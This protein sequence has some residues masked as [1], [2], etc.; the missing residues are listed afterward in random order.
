MKNL[1]LLLAAM[2]T[3]CAEAPLGSGRYPQAVSSNLGSAQLLTESD[4]G[5]TV[6]GVQI[7][8]SAGLDKESAATNGV[9]ALV[10]ECITRTPVS[11]ASGETLP[12]R[13]AV[14]AQGGSLQYTVDG[15]TVHFYVEGRSDKL[16][17]L[18][19]LLTH[20]L[21]TPDFSPATA[22][23]A[24][25]SLA[26]RIGELQSNALSV[27]IEMF[28]RSYFATNAGLPALG[29]TNSLAALGSRDLTAFYQQN[30]KRSGLVFSAVGKTDAAL[31]EAL[32][33]LA[34]A[35]PDGSVTPVAP[36]ARPIPAT[37]PRIVARR[38]VGAP[39]VVVGFAAP[40][41]GSKDFG[42]M[43]VL[44]SLLSSAFERSSSTTLGISE[45]SVGAF[46]LYD[47]A[48]ASLVVYVNGTRV[49]PSL[50]LRELLL[51]SRSLAARP[52]TPAALARFKAQASGQFVI[53]SVSISDRAYLLGTF[54]S[55]GL[56]PDAINAA[57]AA[58]D[59]T[60][61]ADVQRVAKQYLQR[62]IVALILPR[63]GG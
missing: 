17:A 38:D 55:H 63:Q 20:A 15:S 56:G 12:V 28:R 37:A 46:Y 23:A 51:V 10:A 13:D 29:T 18:V 58:V 6:S 5:A 21:A 60:T 34:A 16:P 1:A 61:P 31:S 2:L 19:N 54:A 14:I 40:S 44:E 53:D 32:S 62:Y 42:A 36:K 41:P 43:V 48:P 30:Y 4:A 9:A 39:I 50:A 25:R 57:L 47:S 3:L 33:A 27:G 7:F 49:D 24:R 22:A 11:V 59:K 52:L 8:L 35:L 45:R 26:T